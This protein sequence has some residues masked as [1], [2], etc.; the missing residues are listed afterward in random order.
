MSISDIAQ[1]II[2]LFIILDPIGNAP[3]FH[4]ITSFMEKNQRDTIIKKSVVIAF[5]LLFI[6]GVLGEAL[7]KFFGITLND[8]RIAGGIILFIYGIQ[9]ILGKSQ[10]E[11]IARDSSVAVI[12]LATPLLAGPGAL[13]TVI[14]IKYRWGI[15]VMFTSIIIGCLISYI[16]LI[17]GERLFRILGKDGSML[18]VKLFSM[19]L[20]AIAVSMI[21][22][23]ILEYIGKS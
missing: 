15:G 18:L 3:I 23:G 10:A 2:M 19:I 13:A 17:S 11:D 6:I 4:S 8:F 14:F 16:I 20:A 22:H 5:F 21:A 9:G 7:F 1:A 12:P